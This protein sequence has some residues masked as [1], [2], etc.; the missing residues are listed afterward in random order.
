MPRSLPGSPRKMLPPPMTITTSTP[1]SRT[2]WTCRAMS[3]TASGQMPM[4]CPPP[5]ASPESLSR[6]RRYR[7]VFFMSEVVLHAAPHS[8]KP[9]C[10]EERKPLLH[11]ASLF[12]SPDALQQLLHLRVVLVKFLAREREEI[13][14]A[15]ECLGRLGKVFH[16]VGQRVGPLERVGPAIAEP[17]LDPVVRV[18]RLCALKGGL[19]LRVVET[20]REH[21]I[22]VSMGQ[23]VQGEVRHPSRFGL[24]VLHIGELHA[25]DH[26]RIPAV[27][28]QPA[29]AR[30]I[31][32][33]RC[34]A[35][36]LR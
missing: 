13:V 28:A 11:R 3:C 35:G 23:F 19:D 22:V 8:V 33:A 27:V 25:L 12:Q 17:P 1:R 4:P 32:R 10:G 6:M 20:A 24:E 7:A 16:R 15:E 14:A 5:R 34:Q 30:M 26:R 29:G 36:V 2:S 31:L 18:A 9:S 21:A